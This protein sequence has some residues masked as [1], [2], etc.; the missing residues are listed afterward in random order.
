MFYNKNKITSISLDKD[1][2]I[3]VEFEKK[4]NIILSSK[5]LL[6]KDLGLFLKK[7]KNIFFNID[8]DKSFSEEI[9][10]PKEIIKKNG[11]KNYLKYY[12]KKEKD[13][14]ELTYNYELIKN[15]ESNKFNM[16]LAYGT[17]T[18]E[19]ED[20]LELFQNIDCINQITL[21]KY[22]LAAIADYSLNNENYIFICSNEKKLFIFASN[23]KGDIVFYRETVCENVIDSDMFSEIN[24]IISYIISS[25]RNISFNHI[26]LNG[27]IGEIDN[28]TEQLLMLYSLSIST[29]STTTIIPGLKENNTL[30][31]S[32]L[33]NLFLRK[34]SIIKPNILS[35]YNITKK[36]SY[37]I[38]FVL[39]LLATFY[40][41]SAINKHNQYISKIK[42]Y[43][44][45]KKEVQLEKKSITFF[46]AKM[47][48]RTFIYLKIVNLY[49]EKNPLD[50]IIKLNKQVKKI[51]KPM[52]F[53]W[54][55]ENGSLSL[56]IKYKKSFFNL[57]KLYEYSYIYD[58]TLK[59][60]NLGVPFKYT[61][62]INKKN[63]IFTSLIKNHKKEKNN[64]NEIIPGT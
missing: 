10:V 45:I 64:E 23:G 6:H 43:N 2:A 41:T 61:N 33:G 48:N 13:N 25:F 19:C 52:F 35:F 15:K 17:E 39:I 49:K 9:E 18:N 4:K 63:M 3:I 21:K 11:I 59:N 60:T 36:I 22:A 5:I 37:S 7:K 16:Y 20:Y 31:L 8:S 58:N 24:Q 28:V 26:S 56:Q 27:K 12:L 53:G 57:K 40:F 32:T 44:I 55:K 34:K 14:K 1:K 62:K 42:E 50:Q 51:G 29:I 30:Y 54:N 47:L 38:L 46:P